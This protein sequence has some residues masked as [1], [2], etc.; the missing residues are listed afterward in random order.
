MLGF[1]CIVVATDFTEA[2]EVALRV[3]VKLARGLE[4]KLVLAHCYDLPGDAPLI[5]VASPVNLELLADAAKV[6]LEGLVAATRTQHADTVSDLRSGV[7]EDEIRAVVEAHAAD[8]LVVGTHGR[9]GIAR[10]MVGSVAEK[11]VRASLIPVVVVPMTC[12]EDA[13]ASDVVLV[14]LA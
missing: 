2:S 9:K 8:L 13:P 7:F 14:P 12:D 3:A 1:R 4:A 10:L 5:P 11:V 6:S